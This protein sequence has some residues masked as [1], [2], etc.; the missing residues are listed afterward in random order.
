VRPKTFTLGANYVDIKYW[1]MPGRQ[2]QFVASNNNNINGIVQTSGIDTYGYEYS[3]GGLTITGVTIR[4]TTTTNDT[5]RVS[6]S[7]APVAGHEVKYTGSRRFGNL[8]DDDPAVA[9]YKDQDWT[10]PLVSGSPVYKEGQLNDL[11]NWGCA[12]R[13]VL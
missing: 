6:L 3:G 9:Y 11:R 10:Q 8:C 5:V 12:F 2:L 1:L 13:K 4:T 7:G